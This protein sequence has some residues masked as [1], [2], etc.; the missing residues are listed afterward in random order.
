MEINLLKAGYKK[1]EKFYEVFL[2]GRLRDS[3]FISKERLWIPQELPEFPVFFAIKD[4]AERE[5]QF[6]DMIK[7][8]AEY[9]ITMD[10]DIFM[11]ERFWHSW[12]CMYRRDYLLD[13][14]PQV[15][16]GYRQFKNIILKDFNWENYIYK[17]ILIAQY[18]ADYKAPEDQGHM[19]HVILQ[20]MDMFNYIIKYEI[21]RNGRFL[22]N[23]MEIIEEA[24]L[25]KV[26]KAKIKNRPDLGAD[27]RYGRR[28]I[29]EF[30]K[31]Y[32][33]V[34]GPMLDKESMKAY[35]FKYLSYYYQGE[36]VAAEEEDF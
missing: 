22:I 10:R 21:F 18:V 26:L 11:D 30:N 12:I 16:E 3:E 1:E 20:N 7:I 36:A 24:G 25:S 19:Y 27:E 33:I 13:L 29:F 32:P 34:L 35:F 17:A 2:E 14:Y 31:S 15:K 6:I 9:V 8:V 5:R 4:K 28:V 23:I